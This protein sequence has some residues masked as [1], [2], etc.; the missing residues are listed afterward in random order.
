LNTTDVEVVSADL[1]NLLEVG[2]DGGSSLTSA[3]LSVAIQ[4]VS[5]TITQIVTTTLTSS[6]IQALETTTTF[7]QSNSSGVITYVDEDGSPFTANVV[8]G[9]G[10]NASNLIRVGTDG[11]AFIDQAVINSAAT[12]QTLTS[13]TQ[14]NATGVITYID[15]ELNTTDVEVVSADLDNLLEVGSDGGSSLTSATLSVAIQTV[16]NTITQIVTTTLTSS[17]IQ[18]LE[19]TT[20]LAQNDTTGVITYVNEDSTTS[21]VEVVS[22]QVSNLIR[23]GT[24]GGAFIDQSVINSAAT[25]QTLTS[26]TQD[27]ATGVITY[28]DEQLNT[29]DVEVVSADLDNLLEVGSDGGS[30]L[31]SATLS[32]AIQTV[33]NTITQIVTTTLTSSTIQALETTT[34]L[35]Q[36]DATGLITYTD[37]DGGTTSANVVSGDGLDPNNILIVGSDGGSL[38]TSDTLSNAIRTVSN[39]ITQIV[40][41]TLTSSTIQALETTTVLTQSDTTGVITYVDEDS[42]TTNVEVTSADPDNFLLTGTDGG[43]KLNSNTLIVAIE[44]V[45]STIASITGDHLGNHIAE[46]NIDLGTYQLVGDSRNTGTSGTNGLSVATNGSVGINDTTP[47]ASAALQ[48]GYVSS[49]PQGMLIP[50]INLQSPTDATSIPSPANGLMVYNTSTIPNNGMRPGFYW[51][52]GSK[53]NPEWVTPPPPG[54]KNKLVYTATTPNDLITVKQGSFE[55]RFN[56]QIAPANSWWPEI[57]V[58][59][60]EPDAKIYLQME[61]NYNNNYNYY[62]QTGFEVSSTFSHLTDPTN[63]GV[64]AGERNVAYFSHNS[65]VYEVT[66]MVMNANVSGFFTFIIYTEELMSN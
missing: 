44:S 34:V 49:N 19:T 57:R 17:T 33:S 54:T 51:N 16:S 12:S 52:R 14:D 60:G 22:A 15:E 10:S 4:T 3:T 62:Y 11:G 53:T 56:S 48:V 32:V 6:T 41:T 1:D 42:D 28:E 27:N 20:T 43:T 5:N 2:S 7:A 66:F 30:S 39:T 8:S 65:S 63:S 35:G 29:T 26:L 59:P 25:S 23:V 64:T 24:D 31:T 58:A 37:E 45:S 61:E 46:Q 47:D 50:K 18:A 38:L 9:N 36:N 21:D 55:F 40:T 13:L